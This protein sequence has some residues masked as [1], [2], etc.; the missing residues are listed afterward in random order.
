MVKRKVRKIEG[1]IWKHLNFYFNKDGLCVFTITQ[2]KLPY[3]VKVH[4]T[5]EEAG[6]II[7]GKG[8]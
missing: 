7:N 8:R 1:W 4:I 5:I 2:R 3:S 6:E